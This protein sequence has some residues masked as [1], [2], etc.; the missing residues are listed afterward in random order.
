MPNARKAPV[1][2]KK[3]KYTAP[4]VRAI[5]ITRPNSVVEKLISYFAHK[6]K[7]GYTV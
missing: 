1:K 3:I 2:I 7:R 5:P 6:Q 4:I